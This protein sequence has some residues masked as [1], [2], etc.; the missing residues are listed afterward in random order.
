MRKIIALQILILFVVSF[1]AGLASYFILPQEKIIL[2]IETIDRRVISMEHA[3]EK[4][5]IILAL[6][7]FIIIFFLATHPYLIKFAKVFV[8]LKIC[9]FGLSSMV[10]LELNDQIIFYSAWWFPFQFLY[11]MISLIFIHQIERASQ[12]KRKKNLNVTTKFITFLV[13]YGIIVSVEVFILRVLS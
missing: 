3:T 1:L 2:F 9:F 5:S 8:S 13:M 10:L 6:G 4:I 12:M 7:S 11:C